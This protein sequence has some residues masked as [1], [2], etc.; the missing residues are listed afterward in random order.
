MAGAGEELF[1]GMQRDSQGEPV[2]GES[3]RKLGAR[4]EIDIELDEDAFVA[5]ST[6]GMSVSPDGPENLPRHRRPPEWG[7]TGLDPVWRIASSELGDD[8]LYRSDPLDPDVHGFIEPARAM[9]FAEY[10]AL[11]EQTR[12]KWQLVVAE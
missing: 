5:P 1:R 11:L 3:A 6:G 10:Q 4:R 8:L 12:S 2:L 9:A 7:G